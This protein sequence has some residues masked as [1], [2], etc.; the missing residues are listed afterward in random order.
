[1]LSFLYNQFPPPDYL[2]MPA[3]GLDISDRALK[4]ITFKNTRIGKY[5]DKYQKANIPE[6]IIESGEIKKEAELADLIRTH[7]AHTG[8]KYVFVTLPEE[9]GY[10]SVIKLPLLK[11]NEV[12]VALESAFSQ[13]IPLSI[14]EAVFDYSILPLQKGENYMQAI[15]VA[16][17]AELVES[18]YRTVT[19]AGFIP[20]AFDTEVHALARAVVPLQEKGPFLIVDFGKTRTSFIIVYEGDV[21]FSSTISISGLDLDR[22]ISKTL[23]VSIEKAEEIKKKEINLIDSHRN[24][25]VFEMLLPII[26]AIRDEAERYIDFWETHSGEDHAVQIRPPIQ[27]IFLCG[28]DANL[29]GFSEYLAHNLGVKVEYANVWSNIFSF[30]EYIPELTFRESLMYGS[31]IGLALRD[32]ST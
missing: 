16:F 27:K 19:K 1:M 18:Y 26:S 6:G 12:S 4:F 9:K 11:K 23:S 24:N 17:P 31:A 2:R 13:H 22:A 32:F 10:M 25:A 29:V 3:F 21:R 20:L 15:L 14:H 30:E 8:M 7:C 5:P 28:G